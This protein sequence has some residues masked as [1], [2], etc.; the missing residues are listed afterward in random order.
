M[1]NLSQ[2]IAV[3]RD[4]ETVVQSR[5][6]TDAEERSL[7]KTIIGHLPVDMLP[8][9]AALIIN[10]IERYND[11]DDR[12]PGHH[13]QEQGRPTEGKQDAP[14]MVAEVTEVAPRPTEGL[15]EQAENTASLPAPVARHPAPGKPKTKT[16]ARP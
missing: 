15:E 11:R 7:L 8:G 13:P 9:H 2:S 12:A 14:A 1:H 16:K 4:A 10:A 5:L 3:L 6:I